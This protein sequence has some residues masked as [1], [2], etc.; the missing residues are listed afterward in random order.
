MWD[1]LYAVD[2][3]SS[4]AESYRS[5]TGRTF[6]KIESVKEALGDLLKMGS[7]PFGSRLGVM[8]FQAPTRAG[9]LLLAGGEMV[10][11][12]LPLTPTDGMSRGEL[13]GKLSGIHVSGATPSG[14][15][16]EEGLNLLC[17]APGGRTKR[18]KR[19]VMVTDERSNVG[20]KPER[21]VNDGVAAKAIIDVIAI[22]GKINRETLEKV[23][24]KTGGK[25]TVVEQPDE[26]RDAMDPKIASMGLGFDEGILQESSR[27]AEGLGAAKKA[28]GSSME[29]RR[30]LEVTKQARAR[31][32]R[33]LMEVTMLRSQSQ[34][35]LD[36]L[37]SQIEKELPMK[38]YA[39]RVWPRASELEQL[40]KVE[41]ELRG[42]LDKLGA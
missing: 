15:A 9:G 39:A 42:A 29:L 3:S 12:V 37:V 33:R 2:A 14:I 27:A 13:N 21:V 4:M 7:F 18:I 41:G 10:K 20:P 36:L 19:L 24:S 26:L 8:T 28:G 31:V 35:E 23:A 25:F 6:V 1:I 11:V 17:G 22:G 30:A 5:Q 32:E 38:D 16:I 34:T 40:L